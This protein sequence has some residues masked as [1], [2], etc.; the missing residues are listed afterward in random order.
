MCIK[1]LIELLW[2][3]PGAHEFFLDGH[4]QWKV[5]QSRTS[6]RG[7]NNPHLRPNTSTCHC[8]FHQ[9]IRHR[10]TGR[11]VISFTQEMVWQQQQLVTLSRHSSSKYM[12]LFE[13]PL[14]K[15][16]HLDITQSHFIITP[17]FTSFSSSVSILLKKSV[18]KSPMHWTNG[19]KLNEFK[20]IPIYRIFWHRIMNGLNSS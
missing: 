8:C 4:S 1:K 10:T 2:L 18:K 13:Y 11:D 19:F 9:L 12:V 16:V 6:K 5:S 15:W 17:I 14:L 3:P 7:W 20:R